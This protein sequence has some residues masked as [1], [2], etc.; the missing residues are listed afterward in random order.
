MIFLYLILTVMYILFDFYNLELLTKIYNQGSPVGHY[1]STEVSSGEH[2]PSGRIRWRGPFW[3][4]LGKQKV[5][6]RNQF[7]D[8]LPVR[9][10]SFELNI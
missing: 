5:T 9:I 4:L 3:L 7:A 8:D 10:E 1:S 2:P 6:R